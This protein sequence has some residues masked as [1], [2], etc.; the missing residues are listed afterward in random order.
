MTHENTTLTLIGTALKR[1]GTG[2]TTG[3]EQRIHTPLT[4]LRPIAELWPE[5]I[6]CDPA[7]SPDSL[8]EA[9]VTMGPEFEIKDSKLVPWPERT[10][11]NPPYDDLKAFLGHGM[12]FDEQAW[13]I[14]VRSHRKWWR[15]ARRASDVIAWLNPLAFVGFEQSFPAALCMLYRGR[16]RFDF[17]DLFDPL[18]HPEFEDRIELSEQ[19]SEGPQGDLFT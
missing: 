7:G 4:I 14:P 1:M 6:A 17:H 5:G 9:E 19:A 18:G 15:A 3:N 13:L 8:V 12:Q 11:I 10:F 16:R 2:D